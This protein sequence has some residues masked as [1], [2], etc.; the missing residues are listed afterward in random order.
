MVLIAL[1]A[2]DTIS[3]LSQQ[4]LPSR[5]LLPCGSIFFLPSSHFLLLSVYLKV[6]L[7]RE[8]LLALRPLLILAPLL[9]KLPV[10]PLAHPEARLNF[11][12]L[13]SGHVATAR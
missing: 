8:D 5:F 7:S 2:E 6:L 1:I 11:W 13:A 9:D 4:P 12:M 3:L 10:A